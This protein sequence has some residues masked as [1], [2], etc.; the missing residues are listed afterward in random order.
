MEQIVC[1]YID[2]IYQNENNGYT[3]AIMENENIEF[4]A[5]GIFPHV[6]I[7]S[8]LKITGSWINNIKYGEQFKV[9]S[10]E[11]IMPTSK[12]DII[13]YLGSGIIYGI[14]AKTAQRIVDRFGE[15]T[16]DILEN[17]IEKLIE[18]EGIGKKKLSEIRSSYEETFE[19]KN[20]MIYFQKHGLTNNQIMKIYKLYG[21]QSIDKVNQNPYVL[22]TEIWGIGFKIADKIAESI[23]IEKNSPFRIKSGIYYV[24]N[25]GISSGNTS[26]PLYK[27][28]EV[29]YNFLSVEKDIIEGY[30]KELCFEEKIKAE[31]INN[32]KYIF[33]NQLYQAE[34]YI[35][36]K[37]LVLNYEDVDERTEECDIDTY[38]E[39]FEEENK[40]KFASL[41][42]EAI[43]SAI[44]NNIEIITGG[45]GTG[46]TTIINCIIYIFEKIKMKVL[47]SA[48][49]G[50][51]AKRITESTGKEAKTIHRLLEIGIDDDGNMVFFKTEEEPV[52]TDVLIID[53]SSMIDAILL[54]NVLRAIK[55]GTKLIFVGDVD[56]L[57]SVGPGNILKD[58][59]TSNAFKVVKLD[60]IFRQSE[61]SMIIL[62]AH[63]I[64]NGELPIISGKNKDFFFMER[65]KQEDIVSLVKELVSKR[66]PRY[67]ADWDIFK[68]IQVLTPS[69]KNTVG[70]ENLNKELQNILNNNVKNIREINYRGKI[71]REGDKVMQ[72]RNNYSIEWFR[73][74]GVG[75]SK[76]VGVF[77]GDMGYIDFVDSQN[78]V[79]EIIF[80]DDKKVTYNEENFEELEHGYAITIHKSQGSEFQV[81][82]LPLYMNSPF[83]MS[84]NL[85][86]TAITRAKS[87][88]VVIGSKN[89]LEYMI[90]NTRSF[91]RYS[92]L[93][94]FISEL[95]SFVLE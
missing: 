20:V 19:F 17:N 87:V 59:I 66:L 77:N 83:L 65:D 40:I 15:D 8:T 82:V 95:N 92:S 12:K 3:V 88:V 21:S 91:D 57:P 90:N 75:D 36:N 1:K 81:V 39:E 72:I 34:K 84:R 93:K 31:K 79:L 67:N 24:L 16:F 30:V 54:M 13:N 28:L 63:K 25:E 89:T 46:K 50:R 69:R 86:Y 45:P 14:G 9:E 5:T 80:D 85:L 27:V 48:P 11:E 52:E 73:I 29:A 71:F 6:T 44:E 2:T 23:G 33:T 38:I 37:L 78:K 61:E 26:M 55:P 56:Q 76:G 58:I 60:K 32:E 47:L 35:A 94:D 53:E 68:D 7:N 41:Q 10:I 42:I 62:N 74:S 49:T 51:A 70:V 64:N 43:K 22:I 4:T 18:V